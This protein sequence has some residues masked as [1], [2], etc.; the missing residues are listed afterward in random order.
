LDILEASLIHFLNPGANDR[1]EDERHP[2]F[3]DNERLDARLLR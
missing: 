2:L 1:A 3:D